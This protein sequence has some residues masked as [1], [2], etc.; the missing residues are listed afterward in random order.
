M[1]DKSAVRAKRLSPGLIAG[2]FVALFFCVSLFIRTYLPYDQVFV[3]DWVKFTSIDAYLHM[4]LVDSI[5]HNFP[6]LTNFDPYLAYPFGLNI[7]NIHF[8]DWLLAGIIWVIGL[9]SPTQHTIDV[10]SAYFPAVLAALTVIPVYFIGKEIYGRRSY[11]HHAR[12][13]PRTLH[14]GLHRPPRC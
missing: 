3:G 1:N 8:F 2:L 7:D 10:I 12:G 11:R 5:V 4:R 13:I 9:G 6:V 14:S